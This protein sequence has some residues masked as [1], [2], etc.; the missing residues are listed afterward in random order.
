MQVIFFKAVKKV[1]G[2][3]EH[4]EILVGLFQATL[5]AGQPDT[6]N[7]YGGD[8]SQ[9]YRLYLLALAKSADMGAMNR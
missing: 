9:A 2:S 5:Q 3:G 4:D 8:L 6:R 1:P 7:F